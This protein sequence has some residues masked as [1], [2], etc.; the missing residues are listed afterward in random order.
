MGLLIVCI[1]NFWEEKTSKYYD[2]DA[3]GNI[4]NF[5]CIYKQKY[6]KNLVKNKK[7]KR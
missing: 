1:C 3:G 7:R 2:F 5:F 4:L 6:N